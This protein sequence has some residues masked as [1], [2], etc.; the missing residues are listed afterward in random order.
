MLPYKTVKRLNTEYK[1]GTTQDN[2]AAVIEGITAQPLL[3]GTLF[4]GLSLTSG[5]AYNLYHNLRRAYKGYVVTR[6]TAAVQL[7]EATSTDSTK[8]LSVT[9]NA[10][11]TVDLWVF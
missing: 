2:L 4:T 10:T 11:A 5:V 3:D 6:M 1:L 8:I 9:P 7:V